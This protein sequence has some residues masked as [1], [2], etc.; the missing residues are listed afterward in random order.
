MEVQVEVDNAAAI[1]PEGSYVAVRMGDFQKQKQYDSKNVYRFNDAKRF[2]RIDIYQRTGT[3]DFVWGAESPEMRT[4]KVVSSGGDTGI[5]LRVATRMAGALAGG[6]PSATNI[7]LPPI[8]KSSV[9]LAQKVPKEGKGAKAKEASAVAK[10]Y[11][12]ENDVEGILTSSMRALLKEMP[13]DAPAFLCKFIQDY[14]G[15][16][17]ME[18]SVDL[19]STKEVANKTPSAVLP[20]PGFE[21]ATAQ[22]KKPLK[23]GRPYYLQ[24]FKHLPVEA[25]SRIHMKFRPK[26]PQDMLQTVDKLRLRAQETLV[27]GILDGR[28]ET[29]ISEKKGDATCELRNQAKEALVLGLTDGRLEQ[30]LTE[31]K[32]DK[33]VA[34]M[35]ADSETVGQAQ[36]ALR[37]QAKQAL[38]QGLSDGRL[39]QI[40]LESKELTSVA[41]PGEVEKLRMQAKET[42]IG[43]I[44]DGRLERVMAA[45]EETTQQPEDAAGI[46]MLKKQ[47]RE[48]LAVGLQTG[49]FEKLISDDESG[50]QMEQLRSQAR[51]AFVKGLETGLLKELIFDQNAGPTLE[52]LRSQGR[53]ALTRGLEHLRLQTQERFLQC[54]SKKEQQTVDKEFAATQ[55]E[56][57]RGR[58]RDVLVESVSNGLLEGAISDSGRQFQNEVL[59]QHARD[60]LCSGIRRER[61]DD[62]PAQDLPML[63]ETCGRKQQI[64]MLKEQARQALLNGLQSGKLQEKLCGKPGRIE[65]EE[66]RQHT[67]NALVGGLKDGRLAGIIS[68]ELSQR[69]P[70]SEA[71]GAAV[72]GTSLVCHRPSVGTWL[73][74][75]ARSSVPA[76]TPRT[77]DLQVQH[78]T[79]STKLSEAMVHVSDIEEKCKNLEAENAALRQQLVGDIPK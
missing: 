10:K 19:P 61:L 56:V 35:E 5:R 78:N 21:S 36:A 22:Q 64:D 23:M 40:L 58:A 33:P 68:T 26:D 49:R 38:M 31:T 14:Y 8:E 27:S 18:G 73:Q 41:S 7:Q 20:S 46:E 28:L 43:G 1:L 39:E 12:L 48:A 15:R 16:K 57:V 32:M 50:T 13:E 9:S 63:D 53:E 52:K 42:L 69:E 65:L 72:E 62:A 55:I 79:L 76:P 3:C 75:R 11:L 54:I 59:R 60:T 67:M 25:W 74:H 51:E 47:A 24:H 30:I 45:R 37:N 77:R 66:L 34:E 4:C 17:K 70:Q 29:L 2:G 44:L 71:S 6:R